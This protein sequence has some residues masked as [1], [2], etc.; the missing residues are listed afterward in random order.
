MITMAISDPL[1]QWIIS[2]PGFLAI[3]ALVAQ[4]MNR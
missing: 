3:G 1:L 4:L 2:L